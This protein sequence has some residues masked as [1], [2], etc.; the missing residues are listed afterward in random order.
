LS[1]TAQGGE[2]GNGL[3]LEK[4]WPAIS[5]LDMVY[6]KNPKTLIWIASLKKILLILSRF[7]ECC[8]I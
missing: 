7:K 8:C 6:S 4:N 3:K 1:S 2:D 5:I